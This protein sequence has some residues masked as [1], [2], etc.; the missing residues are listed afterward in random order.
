MVLGFDPSSGLS[1]L[2]IF[3]ANVSIF[4]LLDDGDTF[5]LSPLL[6][7]EREEERIN[8]VGAL[9]QDQVDSL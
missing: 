8:C 9:G 3:D 1:S 7:L 4:S 2:P 5:S 6:L